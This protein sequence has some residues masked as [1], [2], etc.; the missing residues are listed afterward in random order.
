MEIEIKLRL[1]EQNYNK[2]FTILGD[3]IEIQEQENHYFRIYDREGFVLPKKIRLRFYDS[4]CVLTYKDNHII[5]NGISISGEQECEIDYKEAKKYIGKKN[6]AEFIEQFKDSVVVQY[7][8]SKHQPY[9]INHIGSFKNIRHV[10]HWES[11]HLEI[12]KTIFDFGIGYE[13][14]VELDPQTNSKKV[15]KLL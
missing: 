15:K 3:P 12:D 7:L 14:E 4:K 6:N 8:F 5:K 1:N 2:L 13:I 11:Y 10:F 9:S